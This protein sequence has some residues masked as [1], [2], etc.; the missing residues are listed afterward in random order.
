VST[1]MGDSEDWQPDAGD[2]VAVLNMLNASSDL[3]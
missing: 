3:F 1:V 2:F